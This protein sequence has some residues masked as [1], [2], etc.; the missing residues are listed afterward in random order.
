[1]LICKE[2][3]SRHIRRGDTTGLPFADC[4]AYLARH[5]IANLLYLSGVI[6]EKINFH[7]PEIRKNNARLKVRFS[8]GNCARYISA[9]FCCSTEFGNTT[10]ILL[11]SQFSSISNMQLG[12]ITLP[13][14]LGRIASQFRYTVCRE[15]IP[16]GNCGS[17]IIAILAIPQ[18]HII[19]EGKFFGSA[20]SIHCAPGIGNCRVHIASILIS[21]RTHAICVS[22]SRA[23]IIIRQETV[24]LRVACNGRIK[25]C[26]FIVITKLHLTCRSGGIIHSNS[27]IT[28]GSHAVHCDRII[29]VQNDEIRFA[30]AV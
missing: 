9:H 28:I 5:I 11:S 12:C 18:I 29:T 7:Q 6:A 16:Q 23:G 15:I 2:N 26:F 27:D 3:Q 1:M 13:T 30:I 14:I 20:G 4:S 19:E 25:I 22:Q 10:G 21:S 24:C 8:F 17:G